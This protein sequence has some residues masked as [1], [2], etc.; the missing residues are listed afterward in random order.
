M[1]LISPKS[2]EHKYGVSTVDLARWRQT[3]QGPEYY[4]I[5]SRVVRY[6]T[7]DLD[8]WFRNP[9]NEHLH[10]FPVGASPDLCFV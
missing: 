2:V 9:A 7:D 10:D 5:S 4:R 1:A 3:G 6:G 8:K